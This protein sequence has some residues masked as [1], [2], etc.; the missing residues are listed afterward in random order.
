MTGCLNIEAVCL[1]GGTKVESFRIPK[2]E[3]PDFPAAPTELES[4]LDWVLDAD[5]D[6]LAPEWEE[7]EEWEL[8]T[9]CALRDEDEL[10]LTPEEEDEEPDLWLGCADLNNKGLIF[11]VWKSKAVRS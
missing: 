10:A 5:R 4:L 11:P 6:A 7:D 8:V 9:L 2:A 3:F 1:I